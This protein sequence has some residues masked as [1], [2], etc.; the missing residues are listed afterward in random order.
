MKIKEIPEVKK[1][2]R[3]VKYWKAQTKIT[4][5]QLEK[6]GDG[7]KQ[8]EEYVKSLMEAVDAAPKP[9]RYKYAAPKEIGSPVSVVSIIS[10]WHIDEVV[11]KSQ[12]EGFGG[13][14]YK[15]AES[16]A[17]DLAHRINDWTNVQRNAYPIDKIHIFGLSDY[18]SGGIHPELEITNSMTTPV[19]IER[20]GSLIG[21][22]TRRLSAN[23]K[24]VEFDANSGDNHGR[25]TRKP[26]YK[27]K[28][29]DNYSYLVHKFAESY[30]RDLDNVKF[31]HPDASK[32]IV[33][34]QNSKFLIEHG[35]TVKSWSGIPF[36]G[37]QRRLSQEAERRMNTD[38]QFHFWVLGHFHV[39]NFLGNIIMNGSL[40]GTTELDH[41]VGRSARPCQ[42]AFLVH[43]KWGVFNYVKFWL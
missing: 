40:G 33:K 39:P 41:L 24:E 5:R 13:Y 38:K 35:D 28:A 42:V 34:V 14:N 6:I 2:Q 22:Y 32:Y 36:Y 19:A 21:E 1:L 27:D 18:I 8:S 15:I 3:D 29:L 31:V 25:R 26:R 37:L 43:P 12:T 23:F 9:T 16:R 4:K 11:K 30:C 17:M 10:D 7:Q 20:A